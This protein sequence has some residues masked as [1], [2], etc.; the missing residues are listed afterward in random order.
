MLDEVAPMVE[1]ELARALVFHVWP[2]VGAD[3][4]ARVNALAVRIEALMAQ[5]WVIEP[6]LPD[7]S[8]EEE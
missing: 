3:E 2:R 4:E 1:L 7:E 8:D 5:G 6:P